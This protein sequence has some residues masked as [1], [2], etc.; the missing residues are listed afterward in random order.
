MKLG[1]IFLRLR[2]QQILNLKVGIKYVKNRIM[3][4]IL[5]ILIMMIATGAISQKA[6]PNAVQSAFAKKFPGI[7]PKS[8]ELEDGKYEA[9]F[10]KEGKQMSVLFNAEGNL[11]ETEME[12]AISQ[13]PPAIASYVQD[14]YKGTVIKEAS[15]ITKGNG[16]KTYEAEVKGQD[17]LFNIEGNFLKEESEAKEDKKDED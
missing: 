4:S 6:T 17:L 1:G 13:L 10:I 5:V 2:L 16:E 15:V 11:L 3:K 8:W 12:I 7:T 14:N 9:E